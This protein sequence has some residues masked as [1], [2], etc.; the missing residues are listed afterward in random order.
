MTAMRRILDITS[1]D[2]V[3]LLRDRKVFLFLL[4]MPL[5]V[6]FLFGFAFG[7]FSSTSDPRLPV[8]FIDQDQSWLS[9]QLHDLLANSEVI[10]LQDYPASQAADLQ[11]AVAGGKQSAGIIVPAGYSHSMLGGKPARLILIADTSTAAGRSVES[12]TLTRVIRLESAVRTADSL[13]RAAGSQ[14]PFTYAFENDIQR[15]QEPPIR[16]SE[17]TSAAI[18]AKSSGNQ[19]LAQ[20]S[21]AMMLQFAIA[22]LLTS[23]SI[24]VNERKS[25]SLQRMLTTATSRAHILL[26]HYLA[27]FI[28]I[29]CQFLVLLT[30]GQVLLKVDYSTSYLGML[31]VAFTAALCIA[32]LGLMI[33]VLAKSEEQ[34]VIYSLIPM[35][36]FAGLGGAWVPL[37]VTGPVFQTIGHISPVAWA[38]D[39]F[40]NISVR[41]LG[42]NSTLIP[43]AA[44]VGY[45]L[46][47]FFL[48][49]WRF[50]T[51]QES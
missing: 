37:D 51:A 40:K 10:L 45:G 28:L 20:T 38:M 12:E 30:F 6:T 2:L 50:Q 36:V 34:A 7:G 3:Q 33:G 25:R 8:G 44:L 27:I 14:V 21:P 24:L 4:F 47:F 22:G 15:W 17:T 23:A 41:S 43:A 49:A 5:V 48:A 1:K 31:L 46:L 42:F 13:E 32:A 39:G 35:F 26:G 29:F 18:K 11:T 19:A 9:R 16:V